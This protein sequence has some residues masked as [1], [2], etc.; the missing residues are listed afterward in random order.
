[1]PAPPAGEPPRLPAHLNP[2]GAPRPAR[3]V[4]RV[5]SILVAAAAAAVVL[6][7]SGSGYG[8]L[9]W[10]DA[11][12]DRVDAFAATADR[13]AAGPDGSTTFLMVG[14]DARTGM[15]KADRRRLHVGNNP[16]TVGRRADTMLLVHVSSR[17]DTVTA[18]SLPRDS[19]VTIPAHVG[20]DGSNVPERRN[21]LNAAYAVGG[22][23]LAVATVERS[24]GVRIDHYVEVDFLGFEELVNAVGGV[25]VCTA[26][27]LRDF[28]AG[29][30]LPAGTTRVDGETGLAYVRARNL[31]ARAD[32]GR[33][34]RQ[35]RFLGAMVS[36]VTR[37]DVLL[38]PRALVRFLDA[39]LGSVRV[40]NDLTHTEM[41]GLATQIRHVSGK[42][43]RFRTV[44]VSDPSYRPGQIGA[45]ALWD[46]QAAGEM[47]AAMRLDT[48]PEP[49]GA[50]GKAGRGAVTVAPADI[51][52]RVFNGA[53]A[54]GLGGR[55]AA[56]LAGHGFEVAGPAQNWR[57]SGLARTVVRY[58]ARYTES[59]KTLAASLPGA[60]LEKVTGLGRTQ[61]IVVGSSYDGVRAVRV[62]AP[63]TATAS[64]G[65]RT[66]ADD[67]CR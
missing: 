53:G 20:T 30:R 24:T 33:I 45:V 4:A 27:P 42:D 61:E 32:L 2:R 51:R 5:A 19:Y 21:K 13:P 64:T 44:P 29:L 60:R 11:G 56:D 39:A 66:A 1:M 31:D 18:V 10:S 47:F 55:A 16:G 35:Q 62:K 7:V 28:K 17:H 12:I 65:G 6:V 59:V 50:A 36:R 14:S 34:E 25:D 63:R 43:V 40:D 37:K 48:A 26:K 58:D 38:D 52:V 8:L 54:T 49:E 46:E 9:V 15:S 57:R 22:P 67:P 41:V 23:S 3:R